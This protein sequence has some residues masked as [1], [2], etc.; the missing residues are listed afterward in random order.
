MHRAVTALMIA[1][2]LLLSLAACTPAQPATPTPEPVEPTITQPPPTDTPAPTDTPEP[3]ATFTPEPT[4][5]PEPTPTIT[6][7]RAATRGAKMT[8]VAAEIE[9]EIQ[10]ELEELGIDPAR[11]RLAWRSD[12]PI[13]MTLDTYNTF[14]TYPFIDGAE[15]ADFVLKAEVSWES[16][17]GLMICGFWMRGE[18]FEERAAHY[19][20]QTLRLSGIPAWDIEYI[21][22]NQWVA[23]LSSGGQ[24]QTTIAI[25]Q[26]FGA[27]NTYVIVA[28]GA[29]MEV[30][31]NG[32]RLGQ[33]AVSTLRDG[34]LGGYI[35]QE[36]G[37][38]TCVWENVWIWDLEEE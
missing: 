34:V 23:T 11:G 21:K 10:A 31:A 2:I 4:D 14:A 38:S 33:A 30:Y 16:T 22:F 12:E 19:L 17:G 24:V 26:D 15:I 18:S 29:V 35:S 37:E 25:D 8:E 5:T 3:T 13:G 27:T 7:D 20:F 36:S 9:G 6:P 1:F 28:D 32:T